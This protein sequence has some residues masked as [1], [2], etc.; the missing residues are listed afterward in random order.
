M[1][2][3]TIEIATKHGATIELDPQGAEV[4]AAIDRVFP[5]SWCVRATDLRPDNDNDT[6]TRAAV[7]GMFDEKGEGQ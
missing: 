4:F 5:E 3:R 7:L 2:W 1:T 6:T